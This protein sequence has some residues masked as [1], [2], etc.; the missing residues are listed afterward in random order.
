MYVIKATPEQSKAAYERKFGKTST[1]TVKGAEMPT[2]LIK[3]DAYNPR[4]S[5]AD[6]I[7]SISKNMYG[8]LYDYDEATIRKKFMDAT[9]AEYDA[10]LAQYDALRNDIKAK[11]VRETINGQ[12]YYVVSYTQILT[13]IPGFHKDLETYEIYNGRKALKEF[14]DHQRNHR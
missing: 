3:P 7:Q 11:T 12:E 1:Y 4:F 10:M 9:K 5:Q 8:G 6:S 2:Q 13:D 14:K